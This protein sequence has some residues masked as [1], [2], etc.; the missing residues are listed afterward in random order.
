[1][2]LTEEDRRL[3]Q[4][5]AYQIKHGLTEEAFKDIPEAFGADEF[6]SLQKIRSR[7]AFLSGIKAERYDCC[8]NSCMAYTGSLADLDACP[9]CK[10]PRYNQYASPR[11]QFTYL[12]AISCL[13]ALHANAQTAEA[14]RY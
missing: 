10:E 7:M 13:I 3:L 14:M 5:F 12:P 8:I 4:A 9:H 11:Q 2:R 6:P 1:M